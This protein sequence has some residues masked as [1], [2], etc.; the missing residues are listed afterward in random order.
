[1]GVFVGRMSKVLE[2]FDSPGAHRV[3]IWDLAQAPM[4][5]QYVELVEDEEVCVRVCVC[6]HERT[7][8]AL[9]HFP[10]SSLL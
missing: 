1:M 5:S 4:V 10:L 8:G 2:G 9:M 3:H 6:M 7:S